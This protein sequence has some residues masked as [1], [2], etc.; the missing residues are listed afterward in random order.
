MT[1]RIRV[2]DFQVP[3]AEHGWYGVI[4]DA[5]SGIST[6]AVY[7]TGQDWLDYPRLPWLRSR[8]PFETEEEAQAWLE[9]Q[10]WRS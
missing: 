4:C 10:G 3:P 9:T 5:G 6:V 2:V 8:V 7:W 1:A